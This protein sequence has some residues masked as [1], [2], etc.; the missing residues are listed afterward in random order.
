MNNLALGI[1][2]HDLVGQRGKRL[3]G[4]LDFSGLTRQ[5]V[6][7]LGIEV[8][9]IQFHLHAENQRQVDV[10]PVIGNQVHC[11]GGLRSPRSIRVEHI[12]C[13]A[14]EGGVV[15]D[16]PSVRV[17]HIHVN[18]VHVRTGVLR[19]ADRVHTLF[20]RGGRVGALD[21]LG[22]LGEHV[23]DLDLAVIDGRGGI[24]QFL[25]RGL[26]RGSQLREH[27]RVAGGYHVAGGVEIRTGCGVGKI[28]RTGFEPYLAGYGIPGGEGY[29]RIGQ[30]ALI[31]VNPLVLGAREVI[32]RIG[33]HEHRGTLHIGTDERELANII[34][35]HAINESA[36]EETTSLAH[37]GD[38]VTG[39]VG[40]IIDPQA[41]I[42]ASNSLV[43]MLFSG[44]IHP[45]RTQIESIGAGA[46]LAAVALVN[47]LDGGGVNRGGCAVGV[48]PLEVHLGSIRNRGRAIGRGCRRAN[49]T[50]E[51][52]PRERVL[53]VT[54]IRCALNPAGLESIGFDDGIL[55]ERN[56]RSVSARLVRA[57]FDSGVTDI[58][59]AL[60]RGSSRRCTGIPLRC[61]VGE[62]RSKR[63]H[64]R[65][66]GETGPHFRATTMPTLAGHRRGD[67]GRR[68]S[69]LRVLGHYFS[70]SRDMDR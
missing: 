18:T 15:R 2:P 19:Q 50:E 24:T 68:L 56:I 9:D 1:G 47:R 40:E 64:E 67:S 39:R 13:L 37:H 65:R 30:R 8:R 17:Q 6:V 60:R 33:V 45:G 41:V 14:H 26:A 55:L 7:F 48:T 35:R 28:A 52:A 63:R 34:S 22:V 23:T 38:G 62:S 21:V 58:R 61:S 31:V 70:I 10:V 36:R 29:G 57:C 20:V 46:D 44:V 16:Y 43:K 42:L 5:R 66:G 4:E 12:E 27:H 69:R 25:Q 32:V 53:G 49:T 11:G 54:G 3:A 51:R 59:R